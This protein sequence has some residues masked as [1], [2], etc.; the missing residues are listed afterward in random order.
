[1]SGTTLDR[2][3]TN[4]QSA[5][6][7][8]TRPA[9]MAFVSDAATEAM[10]TECLAEMRSPQT[11]VRRMNCEQARDYLARNPTPKILIVD[12]GGYEHPKH[13]LANLADVVEPDVKVLVI[14]DRG[15]A[16][17]YRHITRD[18]GVSE[19]VYRPLSRSMM[20]RLFAP[21]IVGED[22][23]RAPAR[24]GRLIT[25]TAA[26]GGVGATTI[27]SNLAWYVAEETGRRT[28]AIDFDLHYGKAAVILGAK[29]NGGLRA[30]LESPDRVDDLLVE[31]STQQVGKRLDLLSSLLELND[32]PVYGHHAMTN[33]LDVVSTKYNYVFSEIGPQ[34]QVACQEL[35]VRTN[36][37]IIVMDPTLPAIR[38]TLRILA[39]PRSANQETR[40][41]V[42][43]N[44]MGRPGSL[45]RQ[46]V[47]KGLERKP[48]IVIPYLPKLLGEAEINGVP[49]VQARGAFRT[50]I[51]ALVQEALSVQQVEAEKGSNKTL[52]SKLLRRAR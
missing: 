26:R 35:S 52:F 9:I 47:E 32:H 13:L 46:E 33:L 44:N 20:T 22:Y 19:Y 40:P 16:H 6:Q 23:A 4:T 48:D 39:Q 43:M 38:D 8:Q 11:D 45:T 17:F 29:G 49:A 51:K 27:M 5:A 12:V 24:G 15:D 7:D 14:G 10:M 21:H 1:M 50:A 3:Q 36:Q 41:I 37:H 31:R 18:L 2:V 30:G 28:L 42:V 25:I 34:P